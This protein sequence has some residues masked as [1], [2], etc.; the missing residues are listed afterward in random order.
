MSR[1][2]S[3]YTLQMEAFERELLKEYVEIAGSGYK[4]ARMLGVSRETMYRRMRHLGIKAN[5]AR[6]GAGHVNKHRK[7]KKPKGTSN[8]P[9]EQ[10]PDE[11]A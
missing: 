8:E 11:A 2:T 3:I 6:G 1:R 5:A 9:T 7:R 4:A 10:R